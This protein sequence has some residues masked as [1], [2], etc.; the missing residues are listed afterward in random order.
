MT[1]RSKLIY[2]TALCL[3]ACIFGT[4]SRWTKADPQKDQRQSIQ[5][6]R[7]VVIRDRDRKAV[8]TITELGNDVTQVSLNDRAQNIRVL[9]ST[10][11]SHDISSI[12]L[13]GKNPDAHL[14]FGVVQNKPVLM[15]TDSTGK[16][17]TVDLE[18]LP[19]R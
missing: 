16:M 5:I 2:G 9:I 4:V 15:F 7:S 13:L 12:T 3:S 17:R 8:A 6:E 1:T 10:D 18:K 11:E 19:T 14:T